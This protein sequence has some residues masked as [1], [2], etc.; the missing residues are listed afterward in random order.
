MIKQFAIILSMTGFILF[1]SNVLAG[2]KCWTNNEGIRE[3][4]YTVPPEYAQQKSSTYSSR[5]V[6]KDV[7]ERAKTDDEIRAAREDRI[8]QKELEKEREQQ[9][10]KQ[11]AYDRVLIAT[12][13]RPEEILDA[14]DRKT[15]V[16][17]G[18]IDLAK[19]SIEKLKNTLANE[20]KKAA[21]ID[22]KGQQVPIDI[23]NSINAIEE[24]IESKHEYIAAKEKEKVELFEKT[25]EDYKRFIQL[26]GIR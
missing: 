20:R 18:Y 19:N 16:I 25:K 8:R 24:Q 9:R 22:R 23:V 14:R 1:S 26:K 17:N 2:Y 5:G 21:D 11:Q 10:L 15:A 12:Y 3:C 7:Q 4:G 13:I 6:K